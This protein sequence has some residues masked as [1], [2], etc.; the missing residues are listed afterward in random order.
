[1]ILHRIIP[2]VQIALNVKCQLQW[3]TGDS[4]I[5][6]NFQKDSK[7]IVK[8]QKCTNFIIFLSVHRCSL[9]SFPQL[10]VQIGNF[11]GSNILQSWLETCIYEII[12]NSFI[13]IIIQGIQKTK[14]IIVAITFFRESTHRQIVSIRNQILFLLPCIFLS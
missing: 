3:N 11:Y 4:K 6:M 14:K 2:V 12:F 8:W 10:S 5:V 7:I 1:M 9:T 13:H